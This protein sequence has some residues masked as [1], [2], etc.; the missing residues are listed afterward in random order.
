MT[1]TS[2]PILNPPAP[3]VPAGEKVALGP[4]RRDLL[5]VYQRWIND[6]EVTRIPTLLDM[7]YLPQVNFS[8]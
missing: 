4:H 5:P 7:A 6:F 1:S 3:R 2:P 8:P